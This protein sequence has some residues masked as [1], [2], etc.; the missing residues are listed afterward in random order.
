MKGEHHYQVAVTW[1]GNLGAGTEDYRAYGRDHLIGAAGKADIAGSADP[2]FRGDATRWNPE[3]LLVASLSACHKLW[4]LHLCATSGIS[5]LA[6]QDDAVGV[7]REDAARGGFFTPVTL[8]PQVTVRDGDDLQLAQ[9]LHEKAHHLCF[10][11]NS[12][13]FPV[14]CEPHAAYATR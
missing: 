3:D 6:Y 8:R 5:V 1:Q 12:V 7:M 13:N 9:Q 14:A 4:Y 10:I 11:A 2:A